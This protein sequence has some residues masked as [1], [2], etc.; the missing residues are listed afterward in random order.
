MAGEFVSISTSNAIGFV[1]VTP[2]P[3]AE[4]TDDGILPIPGDYIPTIYG[5]QTI[6]IDIG[7]SIVYP[8]LPSGTISNPATNVT[9]VYDF[10]TNGMNVAYSGNT[11][12]LSGT[13]SGAFDNEFYQFVMNDRTI[14]I[15]S[16]DTAQEFKALVKYE[17]PSPVTQNNRYAFNVTGP[18]ETGN[19]TLQFDVGQWIV[20]KYQTAV[21]NINS[22]VSQGV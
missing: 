19:V 2:D 20:W 22:L 8:V 7:F 14:Q 17:M 16:P 1:T 5:G 12:T 13:F 21:D 18:G 10:A 3:F 4:L 11:V 6:S 9:A 15:L